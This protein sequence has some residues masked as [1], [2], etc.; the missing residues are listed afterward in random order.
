[1]I[2]SSPH[3]TWTNVFI[4]L[5]FVIF[6]SVLSIILGLGIASSLLIAA[7]RCI[8][9]L[10]VMGLVLDKV[11]A[12]NNIWGVAG[13]A[14]LLNVLA[15]TEATYNKAKR[16]FSNMF[17]LI[18]A[19]MMSGTVPVSILGTNFAMAQH[20]FWKPDQ[21]STCILSIHLLLRRGR[22]AQQCNPPAARTHSVLP[23][24]LILILNNSPHH[25]YDSR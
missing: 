13:I 1:M 19:A 17:P 6:D 10:S 11:F 12:S 22:R 18:L 7:V 4:G 8:I 25:W 2:D 16:R 3:L 21:Y 9:Q 20:P 24:R 15:A 5:L 14:V 23:A